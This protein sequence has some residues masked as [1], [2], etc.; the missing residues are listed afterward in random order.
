L[1]V[2]YW[3]IPHKKAGFFMERFIGGSIRPKEF[4]VSEKTLKAYRIIC[5]HY[6][7]GISKWDLIKALGIRNSHIDGILA[8]LEGTD[9]RISENMGWYFKYEPNE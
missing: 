4:A 5:E 2:V 9:M 6:P 8:S 3:L 1:F 7:G